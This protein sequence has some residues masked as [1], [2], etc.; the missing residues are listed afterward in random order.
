MLIEMGT[1]GPKI[2]LVFLLLAGCTNDQFTGDDSG[3]DAEAGPQKEASASDVVEASATETGTSGFCSTQTTAFFCDDFDTLPDPAA[4]FSVTTPPNAPSANFA[5]GT[6]KTGKGLV[7]TASGALSKA[8]VTKQVQGDVLHGFTFAIQISA[9]QANAVYVRVAAQSSTFT[10]AADGL[11]GNLA[12][13]GDTGGAQNVYPSDAKW[14]VFDVQ[15]QSNAANVTVDKG[16]PIAVP[17][18]AQS[19]SSSTID[20]GIISG[21]VAGGS[22]TF[23]DVA[24]R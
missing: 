3:T 13:K 4:S 2:G 22:V 19:S 6:G 24:L 23:D 8:Y 20:L 21:A 14:H 12:I 15:L 17:F 18:A 1:R 7:V 11:A 5:F 10:L 9:T 16:T